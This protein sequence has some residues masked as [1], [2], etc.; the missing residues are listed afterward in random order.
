MVALN[1]NFSPGSPLEEAYF[2]LKGF[3][4]RGRDRWLLIYFR[5]ETDLNSDW[6]SFPIATT[7]DKDVV[8]IVGHY[9]YGVSLRLMRRSN[10]RHSQW[11]CCEDGLPCRAGKRALRFERCMPPDLV[12]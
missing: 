2:V 11:R 5:P 6:A 4:I 9:G 12:L 8:C 7:A 10:E 3:T 1:S